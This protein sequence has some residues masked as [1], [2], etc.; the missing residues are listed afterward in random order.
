[1]T[2]KINR[3]DFSSE[4]IRTKY[5]KEVIGFFQK[6]R[7]ELIGIIAA[8]EILDFFLNT[9]GEEV[10]KM[11]IGDAKKLLKERMEDLEINLDILSPK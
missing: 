9:A 5:I 1:M 10:Y 2:K 8:G 3:I 4:E 7:N 11:A 6:E